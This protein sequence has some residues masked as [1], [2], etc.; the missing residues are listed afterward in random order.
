MLKQYTDQ[1]EA[2]QQLLNQLKQQQDQIKNITDQ[3]KDNLDNLNINRIVD[4]A[5]LF[6]KI[7][8]EV[9]NLL[10]TPEQLEKLDAFIQKN[11]KFLIGL[12]S[13]DFKGRLQWV[14]SLNNKEFLQYL[15]RDDDDDTTTPAP[16]SPPT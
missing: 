4:L 11:I 16:T 14:R 12:L 7:E 6:L 8:D 1:R 2:Q 10:E 3:A 13:T 5:E 15:R 9:I